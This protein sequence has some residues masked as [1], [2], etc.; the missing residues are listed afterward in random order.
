MLDLAHDLLAAAHGANHAEKAA[1]RAAAEAL[2][3]ATPAANA[4]VR[5]YVAWI[6][7]ALAFAAADRAAAMRFAEISIASS[8]DKTRDDAVRD[9]ALEFLLS[10]KREH[11]EVADSWRLLDRY[12]KHLPADR[13]AL[14]RSE[15]FLRIGM[16]R[17]AAVELARVSAPG[18]EA[19][20]YRRLRLEEL[21]ASEQFEAAL[22]A[23]VAFRELAAKAGPDLA[24]QRYRERADIAEAFAA[25]RSGLTSRAEALLTPLLSD[26][27]FAARARADLAML[28]LRR[29][30]DVA[31][32][33]QLLAPEFAASLADL[34]T[35]SLVARARVDIAAAKLDAQAVDS[36]R[37][38]DALASRFAFVLEQWRA[39]PE[40]SPGVAFLQLSW[41]RDLLAAL[42]EAEVAVG[43]A[44]AVARCLAH[45]LAADACGSLAREHELAAPEPAAF[46]A[47]AMPRNGV[48][49]WFLPAPNGSVALAFDGGAPRCFTLPSDLPVRAW[50]SALRDAVVDDTRIERDVRARFRELGRPLVEWLFPPELRQWLGPRDRWTVM[51]RELLANLPFEFLPWGAP[52]WQWLGHAVAIDHVTSAALAA[53][54]AR[55]G[56]SALRLVNVQVLAATHLDAATAAAFPRY[57]LAIARA[58]LERVL[59][60]IASVGVVVERAGAEDLV[61]ACARA[62][63]VVVVAHG[64]HRVGVDI[65]ADAA[66]ARLRPFSLVL[67]DGAFGA[68]RVAELASSPPLVV[69]ATC[70]AARAGVVR[71]E[72]GQLFGSAWLA[73]GARAVVSAESDLDVAATLAFAREFFAALA[74]GR[75]LAEA[76][77]R[78]RVEVARLPGCEH[79]VMH[80]ALRLDRTLE[81]MPAAPVELARGRWWG[82]GAGLLGLAAAAAVWWRWRVGSQAGQAPDQPWPPSGGSSAGGGGGTFGGG[83]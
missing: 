83:V 69:L 35:L 7:A 71:G 73:C 29:G 61:S 10:E 21:I 59:A 25:A 81:L 28:R 34:S 50:S 72:D 5:E 54:H 8:N 53:D 76:L 30:D 20:E 1:L 15:L 58:D 23:A 13:L 67:R 24:D 36:T 6:A 33:R 45:A 46:L 22:A 68:E 9:Q 51:G 66:F 4:S 11:D 43:G 26:A 65:E 48:L 38:R 75:E 57:H 47:V 49:F 82:I 39:T 56:A 2:L 16:L 12:G 31:S 27:A 32:L 19:L 64:H 44:D 40:H 62:G 3:A 17:S 52:E 18:R 74:D 77:R 60:P 79:P 70:G 41:R 42:C 37:L 55:A 63:A 80:C 14:V 78:A